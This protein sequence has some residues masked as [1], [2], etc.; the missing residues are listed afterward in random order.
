MNNFSK[1]EMYFTKAVSLNPTNTSLLY[2]L[3]NC[4]YNSKDYERAIDVC[5]KI[6][7]LD[8]SFYYAYNRMGMCC[9]KLE[10]EDEAKKFFE[11]SK[12]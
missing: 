10:M 6:I 8:P 9:I 7:N 11:K 2:K 1:A 4:L 3:S 5:R 12:Y